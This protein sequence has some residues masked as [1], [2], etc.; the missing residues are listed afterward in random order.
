M[1][2]RPETFDGIIGQEDV[3]DVLRITAKSC[4]MRNEV[5][6]HCLFEGKPGL[7]KTTL[8]RALANELGKNILIANGANITNLK[9]MMPY[10]MKL[11]EG[12]ILFV[13]EIHSLP[14]NVQEFL[15]PVMEDYRVDLSDGKRTTSINI[16]QFTMIGATTEAGSLLAPLKDRFQKRVELTIY[17]D[18]EIGQMLE[19]NAKKFDLDMSKD[20]IGTLADRS[21][22][23]PRKANSYLQWVRDFAVA[24]GTNM[25]DYP[26]ANNAMNK[27]GVDKEG[28][29]N[30][31]RKY[32][33]TLASIIS[34]T[35]AAVGLNTLV[36]SANID[37]DTILNDIEPYLLRKKI[38]IRTQKGRLCV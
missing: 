23:V 11:K 19:I 12:E 33:M 29:T 17:S 32:L 5:M 35:D 10:V 2:L 6:P 1:G 3:K 31:D 22:G 28:M 34:K 16:P 15:F 9:T 37:N 26:L 24:S 18:D 38:I 4:M 8:A 27:I 36:A 30:Q 25:V 20:A 21:R 13:D 14:P 7:G